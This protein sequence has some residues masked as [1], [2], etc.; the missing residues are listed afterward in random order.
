MKKAIVFFAVVLALFVVA[1]CTSTVTAPV[2]VSNNSVG[3]KVGESEET[4]KFIL[5]LPFN[6]TVD[7]SAVKAA[8]NGGISRIA[9]VDHRQKVVNY[10]IMRTVTW[11]TIVTGE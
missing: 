6:Y 5:F 3:S 8:Q 9:S 7:A 10:F 2:D 4:V 1:G 11:T